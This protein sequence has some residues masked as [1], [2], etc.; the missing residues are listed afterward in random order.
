MENK[1]STNNHIKLTI[2]DLFPSFNELNPKEEEMLLIFQGL[3]SFFNLK[4]ILS[5][6]KI[7]EIENTNQT[8]I[9][10]S[11]IKSNNIMA[12][13]F[14]TIKQGEQWITLN[15]ENKNKKMT[16]NLALSLIDCIKL[17]L[18]C[19]VKNK[20]QINSTFNNI[21][22]NT[23]ALNLNTNSNYTNRNVNK[24]KQVINQIN[25][26]ITKRNTNKALLKGSPIKTNY[27]QMSTKRSP[28]KSLYDLN[29]RIKN[30]YNEEGGINNNNN[31]IKNNNFNTFNYMN[32]NINMNPYTT[33]SKC[34]IKKIDLNSS[35]KTRNSKIA[36][37]KSA[38]N[39]YTSLRT[40]N[41]NNNLGI[42]KMNTSTCSLNTVNKN[43]NKKS[44]LTPDIEI[45]EIKNVKGI[46]GSPG[47]NFSR[48]KKLDMEIYDNLDKSNQRSPLYNAKLKNFPLK[49][50]KHKN[51]DNINNKMKRKSNNY[52]NNIKDNN[53]NLN[54]INNNHLN[55]N[56]NMNRNISNNTHKVN[57]NKC[58]TINGTINDNN[59]NNTFNNTF[60]NINKQVI[61]NK[62]LYNS[63]PI[64]INNQQIN[65]NNTINGNSSNKIKKSNDL[66]GS[67]NSFDEEEKNKTK[68]NSKICDR[69]KIGIYT[70]KRIDIKKNNNQIINKKLNSQENSN[71]LSHKILLK[72]GEL[73]TV[74]NE[75][76][77]NKNEFSD[78]NNNIKIDEYDKI[79]I[80]TDSNKKDNKD[81]D[82]LNN[83]KL[84][85]VNDEDD[86]EEYDENDNYTRIKEDF[87]LLYNDDYVNNIQDDLLKLE[88]ELFIEKMTDLITCYHM[89]LEEKR[90]EN[91]LYQNEYNLSSA[92]FK[93]IN[94]LIKKLE[95]IKIDYDIRNM[96]STYNKKTIKKQDKIDLIVTK[97][98]IEIFKNIFPDNNNNNENKDKINILKSIMMN[99]LKK[100]E[101]RNILSNNQ[102]FNIW[103]DLCNKKKE[104]INKGK[105]INANEQNEQNEQNIQQTQIDNYNYNETSLNN[106]DNN[107]NINGIK[108]NNLDI[109]Y[110]R[111]MPISPIYP[112]NNNNKYIPGNE[113]VCNK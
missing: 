109:A 28:N 57:N 49:E 105:E 77:N 63:K 84:N 99:I 42:K 93:E 101:N 98:E 45:K 30:P 44:R 112:K 15:Y 88:I 43:K 92:K 110:K 58:R 113:V 16:S 48:K 14:I 54:S 87:I 52:S 69:V 64:N 27:N 32:V 40:T 111:K 2:L 85:G 95:M 12:T 50:M 82:I 76:N 60:N 20:S 3:N 39:N 73:S 90:M 7:I 106:I 33:I 71:K 61:K 104:E 59:F 80:E 86:I 10:I 29:N 67:A 25:L 41:N 5:T 62:L 65:I 23:S 38:N 81:K 19:D 89:Q 24:T 75:N 6:Q 53:I 78:N 108:N 47:P 37:K 4:E 9:I 51:E 17:K 1:I 72:S 22:I 56:L 74:D 100:E 26:K 36:K 107:I 31:L 70:T 91:E 66:E 83:D 21:S 13:G 68:D 94:K 8:S 34:S 102:N 46:G 55:I 18:Y 96:K 103:I 35:S 97:T 11:L 79:E